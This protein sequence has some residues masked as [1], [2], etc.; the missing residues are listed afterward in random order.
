MMT[1]PANRVSGHFTNGESPR[2]AASM[3]KAA[4]RLGLTPSA[5]AAEAASITRPPQK[6]VKVQSP[7]L[8]LWPDKFIPMS[9]TELEM[10]ACKHMH[11]LL[12]CKPALAEYVASF[13]DEDGTRFV[14]DEEFH[15]S[16]WDYECFRRQRFNWPSVVPEISLD[17][18]DDNG[19]PIPITSSRS[20]RPIFDLTVNGSRHPYTRDELTHV[21]TFRVYEAVKPK[22]QPIP[23]TA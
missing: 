9:P 1:P 16:I 2:S 15:E 19:G 3:A 23:H 4:E 8:I 14:Q 18:S 6:A 10:H 22:P 13:V 17:M 7:G 21:R 5:A 11:V 12:G 20:Q